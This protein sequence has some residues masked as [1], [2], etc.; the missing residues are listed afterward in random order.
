MDK[1]LC[2][3]PHPPGTLDKLRPPLQIARDMLPQDAIDHVTSSM[4]RRV[5]EC[6]RVRADTTHHRFFV[7]FVKK[8]FQF[9]KFNEN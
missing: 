5:A 1:R 3:L 9:S 6:I 2:R 7:F 4:P 8:Y